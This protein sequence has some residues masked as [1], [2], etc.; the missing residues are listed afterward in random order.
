MVSCCIGVSASSLN[1]NWTSTSNQT[2]LAWASGSLFLFDF[3]FEF[4]QKSILAW[5]SG[6][7]CFWIFIEGSIRKQLFL[8]WASGSLFLL[9]F[10]FK[11]KQKSIDSGLGLGLFVGLGLWLSIVV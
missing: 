4:K 1:S 8:A 7:L 11:F 2:I 9:E 3:I 10:E 6:S 5:A